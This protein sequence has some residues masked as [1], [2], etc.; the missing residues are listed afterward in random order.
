MKKR[1][2][3]RYCETITDPATKKRMF[4]YGAS[5][6][7]VKNKVLNYHANKKDCRSFREIA[8]EWAE[9][10]FDK[11]E[12]NTVVCYRPALKRAIENFGDCPVKDVTPNDVNNYILKISKSGYA[13][14]T[15]KVHYLVVKQI[16]DHGIFRGD[17]TYNPAQT[18]KLPKG[19][20]VGKRDM[21]TDGQIAAIKNN[22]DNGRMGLFAFFLLYSG[23]RKG[24]ALALQ[25]GDIDFENDIIRVKKVSEFADNAAHIK[26]YTKTKAGIRD[27]ILLKKLKEKLL[28][29]KSG[30]EEYIFGGNGGLMTRSEFSKRWRRYCINA[31]MTKNGKNDLVPHQLRHAFV[32]MLYEAGIDAERAM[33]IT[34]HSNITTMRKIYTHIREKNNQDTAEKLNK[35]EW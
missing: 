14:Q 10:H 22:A 29:L 15:V 3:G 11:I 33:L 19:L 20:A 26:N 7:E 4:F 9:E 30:A 17:I 2:D 8:E 24:E 28:P 34:G 31:G 6:S 1:A 27:V 32:T 25:W 5:Q 21:P 16:L 18:V 12:K 13:K 23:L 35:F